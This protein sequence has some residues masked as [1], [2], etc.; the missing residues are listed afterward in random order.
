MLF[1]NAN[2]ILKVLTLS[3]VMG[4]VEEALR[5]Y[6]SHEYEMPERLAVD[7]GD[8]NLLLLMPCVAAG[9]IVTKTLTIYPA[10]PA[11]N[12]PMIDGIVMLAD[13]PTGEILALMDA[14]TITAM[15]T[16][17]VTG[18]SIRYLAKPNARSVGLVGC[19]TQGHFQLLYACAAR[20]IDRITLYD[21]APAIIPSFVQRLSHAL[22]GIPINVA[23][24]TEELIGTSDIVI[25]AT[26]S[27]EPVFPDDPDLFQG[28]HCVAIGSF[29]PDV[30]EYPDAIFGLLEKAWVDIEFAKE[31]SGELIIPLDNGILRE[32]QLETL[33]HFILSGRAPERG[34]HGTTFFKTVGMALFDLTTARLAFN[35][36]VELSAGTKL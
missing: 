18:T 32:E 1:L 12:R 23:G 3:E 28:R 22:P 24:S 4:A 6:E 16:G 7:C 2:D 31:E 25:T 11:R 15:R 13:Q 36:A 27:R 20:D 34:R 19:G 30:R 5:I 17:A 29:Q 21:A 10:N 33:G 26:T 14:K 35:K 8:R 9:S